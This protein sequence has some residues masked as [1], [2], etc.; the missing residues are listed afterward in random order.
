MTEHIVFVPS[1]GACEW[2]WEHQLKYLAGTSS[3]PG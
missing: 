3:A 1:V 2:A